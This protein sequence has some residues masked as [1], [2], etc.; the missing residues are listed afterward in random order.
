MNGSTR[1]PDVYGYTVC[2]I[3]VI[4]ALISVSGLLDAAFTIAAPLGG[5]SNGAWSEMGQSRS[6]RSLDAFRASATKTSTGAYVFRHQVFGTNGVVAIADTLS[7]AEVRVRYQT[8]R[9]DR[10]SEQR[11]K[12]VKGF[13]TNTVMLV[14]ALAL[15]GWHWRWLRRPA[16]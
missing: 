10:L 3:A 8:L 15:F 12:A 4:V 1:A 6:L 7:D 13:V 16:P 9:D 14:F 5:D 2:L 11:F